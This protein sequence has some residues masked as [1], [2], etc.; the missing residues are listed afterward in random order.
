MAE[1]EEL[2]ELDRKLIALH[3]EELDA[4]RQYPKIEI[5]TA[6]PWVTRAE[7]GYIDEE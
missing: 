5:W 7:N 6:L 3:K 4:F 2:D 1:Y